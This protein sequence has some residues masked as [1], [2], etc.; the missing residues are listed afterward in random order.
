VKRAEKYFIDYLRENGLKVTKERLMLLDELFR[1]QAHLDADSLLFHLRNQGRH[2]S[3]ATVYRTLD[4]LVQC[5]LAR[6]SRLGRE[7]YVYEKVTPGRS[8]HHMVCTVTGKII[9]FWDAEVDERLRRI[10]E[11]K[12]FRPTY[13]SISIQGLSPEAQN[14]PPTA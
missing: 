12:G 1:S 9:E 8:H 6:K 14:E 11:E 7:H 5:G 3:R 4:L 10:C 13:I 2:I